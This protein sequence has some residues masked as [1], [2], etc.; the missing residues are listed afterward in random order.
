LSD[1]PTLPS[2]SDDQRALW[3]AL[4]KA[5]LPPD[6]ATKAVLAARAAGMSNHDAW[7][8][9]VKGNQPV[10]PP[11]PVDQGAADKAELSAASLNPLARLQILGKHLARDFK[12]NSDIGSAPIATVDKVVNALSLGQGPTIAAGV[13]AA[14]GN[15][16]FKDNRAKYQASL[17]ED[18]RDHPVASLL[19]T[20]AGV[21]GNP[22]NKAIGAAG[23]SVGGAL[24]GASQGSADA[25]PDLRS[26]VVGIGAGAV[27]GGLI[28]SLVGGASRMAGPSAAEK[29]FL[30]T[31][32][33]N[34][35]LAAQ[36]IADAQQAGKGALL[37]A[38]DLTPET[39]SLADQLANRNLPT[40]NAIKAATSARQ[41]GQQA[42]TLADMRNAV[43]DP[44]A[45]EL[46]TRLEA[47]R[48]AWAAGPNGYG[49]L[50]D[51]YPNL[52]VDGDMTDILKKPGMNAALERAQAADRLDGTAPQPTSQFLSLL[53][54]NKI[55]QS[56]SLGLTQMPPAGTS[57]VPKQ[58]YSTLYTLMQDFDD[59]AGA[60][61]AKGRSALGNAYA[62]IKNGINDHLA[63]N[64]PEHAAVQKQYALLKA[65]EEAVT[66]GAADWARSADART[67]AAKMAAMSPSE[68]YGY[69]HGVASSMIEQAAKSATNRDMA[70]QYVNA[71]ENMTEKLKVVFGTQAKLNTFLKQ[72]DVEQNFAKL[73]AATGG[74]PSA[75]RLIG[76][77][78]T[79]NLNVPDMAAGAAVGSLS[80]NPAYGIG[81][82]VARPVYAAVKQ[83]ANDRTEAALGRLLSTKGDD[84]IQ[85]LL[86][87]LSA[88]NP[89]GPIPQSVAPALVNG[90]ASLWGNP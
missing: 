57:I 90:V 47:Q 26:Q 3:A 33:K 21:I 20:A 1:D 56:Q 81:A 28:G 55:N 9:Y 67:I 44:V 22:L 16:S 36:T 19:G 35:A 89:N 4:T 68:Q 42:R 61:F 79:F 13:Q 66:Q 18:A 76:R 77:D 46:V 87:R 54:G 34:P 32:N 49:G 53:N 45:P 73:R 69:Q 39:Q 83:A 58:S 41:A 75:R 27:G 82:A 14:L 12:G 74:S 17:A 31:V 29:Q 30:A 52:A 64:V 15:G 59:A 71:G 70:S 8:L 80:H 60:A 7:D 11:A 23:P 6:S 84:S 72:M 2:S 43:G 85:Q 40:Y 5:G 65:N 63:D 88:Q 62:T 86:A 10:A 50:R 24:V 38:A 37:T 48:N 78:G 25:A 51:K